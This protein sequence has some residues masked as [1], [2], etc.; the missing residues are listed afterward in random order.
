MLAQ[1]LTGRRIEQSDKQLVPL[2]LDATADPARR[3]AVVRGLD[4]H[5]AIE[6]HRADVEAVVAKGLEWQWTE[7]RLLL[8]KH[9]GDVALRRAVDARVGPVVTAIEIRL[10]LVER[11]EAKPAERRLLR[12]TDAGFDCALAIGIADAAR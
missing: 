4:F 5:T 2:H 7:G 3:G 9:R 1:E 10:R 12:M 11:L 8:R 6:V